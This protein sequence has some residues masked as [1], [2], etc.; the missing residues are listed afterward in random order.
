MQIS[1]RSAGLVGADQKAIDQI[2]L[3]VRLGG[4]GDDQQLIDVG[5]DHVL[6]AADGAAEH[7]VARLDALDDPLVDCR[8]AGTARG[9]R[10]PRRAADRS[11]A[12]CSSRRVAH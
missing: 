5:D 9:R 4:A 8:R 3:E 11:R 2:R 10:P 12:S 6:P 1:G 7:A